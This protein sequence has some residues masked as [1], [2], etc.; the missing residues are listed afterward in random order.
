M[1]VR[2]AKKNYG[3]AARPLCA[4]VGDRESSRVRGA[5]TQQTTTKTK[6]EREGRTRRRRED[7]DRVGSATKVSEKSDLFYFLLASVRFWSDSV[8]NFV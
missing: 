8:V 7:R 2:C 6:P 5:I 4:C 1:K 3:L